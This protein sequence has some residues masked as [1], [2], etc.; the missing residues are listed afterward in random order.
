[1]VSETTR[2]TA[3]PTTLPA[4]TRSTVQPGGF[5]ARSSFS[6]MRSLASSGVSRLPIAWARDS[7]G[8]STRS[9]K[10]GSSST[11]ISSGAAVS[12]SSTAME[13]LTP[14]RSLVR[15]PTAAKTRNSATK[16]EAEAPQ[17]GSGS[18]H[19][20]LRDLG[21]PEDADPSRTTM[22]MHSIQPIGVVNSGLT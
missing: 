19:V 16:I 18:S 2:P 22:P 15:P 12:A 9:L 14:V 6:R 11:F 3:K 4:I 20:H 5:P 10:L 17:A 21:H 1:M 13:R 8:N 7:S